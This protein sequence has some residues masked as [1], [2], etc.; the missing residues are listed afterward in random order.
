MIKL[1]N[2]GN[3]AVCLKMHNGLL[4]AGCYDGFIYVFKLNDEKPFATI[5]GPGKMLLAMSILGNK[6]IKSYYFFIYSVMIYKTNGNMNFFQIIAGC[7]D[8]SLCIWNIPKLVIDEMS[9]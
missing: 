8:K 3:G 7:K 1:Y 6:V 5:P 9:H 2:G 4:F